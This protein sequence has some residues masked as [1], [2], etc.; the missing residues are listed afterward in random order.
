MRKLGGTENLNNF[1]KITKLINVELGLNPE[2]IKLYCL[3]R[4]CV[5]MGT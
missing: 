4:Y 2:S 3:L 5:V 1:F